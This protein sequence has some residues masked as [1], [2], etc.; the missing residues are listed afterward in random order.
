MSELDQYVRQWLFERQ[1]TQYRAFISRLIPTLDQQNIIG[2]RM[3]QIRRLAAELS[4][5]GAAQQYLRGL[6][7]RYYEE[8]TLH[9]LLIGQ[10]RDYERCV[11]ALE[12]F[13]PEVDNWATCD[14]ITPR[15]FKKHPPQ[16]PRQIDCWLLSEH[17]Y[18]RRF[19]IKMLMDLY[20][21]EQFDPVYLRK[22]AVLRSEEYYVRMMAA[23]YFA[24]ALA[25]QYAAALP[26]IEQRRLDQW[27]HNKTIQKAVESRRISDGQKA[28]LRTL[29]RR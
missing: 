16:L 1:D 13:L 17:T 21:D 27:T 24:T 20:L 28:Y 3:P 7:H 26:F 14:A 2:V 4:K 29:R 9:G 25:K 5:S 15:A 12:L 6:P 18:T 19:G 23:W 22:A 10:I 11:A 8:N